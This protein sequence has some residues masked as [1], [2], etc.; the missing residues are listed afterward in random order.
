MSKCPQGLWQ[1]GATLECDLLPTQP[2][3]LK[4]KL[5]RLATEND[6]LRYYY[7]CAQCLAEV[8]VAKGPPIE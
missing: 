2:R 6:G 1:S 7:L 3:K 4:G 5:S 8:E